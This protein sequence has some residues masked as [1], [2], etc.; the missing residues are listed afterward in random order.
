MVARDVH[1]A[2]AGLC[3]SGFSQT[4]S[5]SCA[6]RED[7]YEIRPHDARALLPE[8]RGG[9]VVLFFSFSVTRELKLRR[10]SPCLLLSLQL[11]VF[12]RERL[13]MMMMACG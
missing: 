1:P 2:G 13:W 11:G 12:Y 8:R 5:C 10:E 4:A 9:S 3:I 7:G 6:D